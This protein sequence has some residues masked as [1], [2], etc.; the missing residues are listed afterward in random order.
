[1]TE[2]DQLITSIRKS[3][4]IWALPRET[5]DASAERVKM[6]VDEGKHALV[7]SDEGSAAAERIA[8]AVSAA[9]GRALIGATDV[10]D[11]GKARAAI[12]SGADFIST[13]YLDR[14]IVRMCHRY[15][16]VCIPG[17]LSVTEVLAALETG[18][19]LVGLYPA[20]VFG[21][22]MLQAIKGPLPQANLVPSGNISEKDAGKW[23][24][25]GAAAVQVELA[26][27]QDGGVFRLG[28][29]TPDR[30]RQQHADR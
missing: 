30:D 29:T 1:M 25:A 12:L 23:I 14:D 9:N 28:D 4:L 24:Q 19:D 27:V 5:I 18:C 22:K 17:A 21:P 20:Q 16:K 26:A 15:G 6:F 10:T 7:A 2:K 11:S 13:P 3:G 8:A